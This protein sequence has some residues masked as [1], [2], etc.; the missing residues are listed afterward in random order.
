VTKARGEI[1]ITYTR[2]VADRGCDI[3]RAIQDGVRSVGKAPVG[4]QNERDLRALTHPFLAVFEESDKLCKAQPK[5]ESCW[6][7]RT[8]TLRV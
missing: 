2:R 7:S 5:I 4:V 1:E 3:K 6:Q 8:L